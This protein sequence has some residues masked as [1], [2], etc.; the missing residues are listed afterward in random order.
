M[1]LMLSDGQQGLGW[2]ATVDIDCVRNM[3]KAEGDP[4]PWDRVGL[5]RSGA[6]DRKPL[7][8]VILLDRSNR[9]DKACKAVLSLQ[10]VPVR[11]GDTVRVRGAA[12]LHEARDTGLRNVNLQWHVDR[13]STGLAAGDGSVREAGLKLCEFHLPPSGVR[14]PPNC[15][16]GKERAASPKGADNNRATGCG[17]FVGWYFLELQ[18]AG[19]AI[20]KDRVRKTYWWTPPGKERRQDTT[21]IYFTGPTFGHREI[22]KH[23]ER[24]RR[25]PIY[26]DFKAGS[27][28]RPKPG[29]VYI[30][31]KPDGSTRHVG[32]FAG[33]DGA[34]WRTADGGQG[35]TGYGV[36]FTRRTF[37]AAKG[38]ISG[39]VEVGYVDGWIDLES[40]IARA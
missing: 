40:L 30:I 25:N 35:Q 13:M 33:F 9:A 4:R 7:G 1:K 15:V 26:I 39:G 24:T 6:I 36:G 3:W 29:D 17:G 8:D 18:K 34:L 38:T 21:E 19:Y 10:D 31:R 14:E 11:D 20:P 27:E 16:E 23:V 12:R 2:K 32:V 37:D 5:A 28:L 22:A